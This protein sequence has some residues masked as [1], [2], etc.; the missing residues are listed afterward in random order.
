MH[1]SR[2]PSAFLLI[3][4]SACDRGD[5]VPAHDTDLPAYDTESLY[6][7]TASDMV[8]SLV[9]EP[10]G[11]PDLIA[12]PLGIMASD[13]YLFITDIEQPFVHVLD[14]VTGYHRR[15]FGLQGEGPGDFPGTPLAVAGS[16][17]GDTVWFY[18]MRPGRLSGVPIHNLT[19]DTLPSIS[20]TRAVV[21]ES[22]G[23]IAIDGPDAAG[24]LLGMTETPQGVGTFTYSLPR[25]SMIVQDTLAL[26][27]ERVDSSY[28]GDA[29]QGIL[30]YVPGRDVWLQF[31][32]H[33]GR[34]DI[35]DAAGA[36]RGEV[37]IPFRWLPHVGE[38]TRSPGKIVFSSFLPKTRHA[39]SGCAVT[40]RFVYALYL[41]HM[42]GDADFRQYFERL[43]PGE[44][45]VFDM[46]FNLVKT[47]VL[48]H[49]TTVLAV[50][51]G[52]T[53]LFSVTYDSTGSQVRRT[54]VP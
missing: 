5:T 35:L 8:D 43:P 30:C 3:T 6:L 28:L 53:V 1:I 32:R 25:D 12:R 34:A 2:I 45:Q 51:P 48:D 23:G 26:N 15:S 9:S 31:Y 10:F 11:P 13:R 41:G 52:D 50:T 27:D 14:V 21:P 46:S 49:V 19:V 4:L 22:G 47:F 38:S 24:N 17:R 7:R 54:R 37:S 44:V 40:E 33:A 29:Y 36:I 39:Y 20:A 18:Q 42:N 16:T